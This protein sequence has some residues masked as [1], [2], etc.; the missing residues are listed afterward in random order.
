[1][2]LGANVTSTGVISNR[3]LVYAEKKM[4]KHAGPAVVLDKFGMNKPMPSN[5]TSTIKFRRPRVFA[6]QTTPL[7]EGVTPN[8]TGFSYE[9]VTGTLRQYGQVEVI[10]DQIQDFNE[11][12]VLNDIATQLGE[13]IGRTMEA[14][15]WAVLR[16]G[17]NVFYANGA[18]RAAVNTTISLAKQRAVIR[19]LK[20]QKSMKISNVMDSSPDY[21]TFSVESAYVGV[22]HTDVENDIRDLPGF[23]HVAEYGNRKTICDHEIGSVEDV[24]YVC[25]PDLD[26][27]LDAGGTPGSTVVSTSGSAADVY[28]ILYIGREA[29]GRVMLRDQGSVDPTV[30]PV[31]QKTK[32]DPLG[33]RGYAG[34]KSYHLCL[35][36]NDLWMARLEVGVSAL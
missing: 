24:R 18:S 19:A 31:G 14:L 35:I 1:M 32:D 6:A 25:S 7:A 20:K 13:N 22:C 23:K 17:T 27:F 15:D 29:Y 26:P 33:Q 2:T 36:L 10:T 16:A 21:A 9:D 30:I 4:L 12:P 34:W 11:D 28:P 5:K 8:P 3:T